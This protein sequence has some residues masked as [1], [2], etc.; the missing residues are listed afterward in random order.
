MV[1]TSGGCLGAWVVKG[2]WK[3]WPEWRN[4]CVWRRPGRSGRNVF[5][6]SFFC[7]PDKI[8]IFG[9]GMAKRGAGCVLRKNEQENFSL[10]HGY[11]KNLFTCRNGFVAGGMQS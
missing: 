4:R 1:M 10:I 8:R 7:N 9:R 11:A 6:A 2:V 5:C 3:G